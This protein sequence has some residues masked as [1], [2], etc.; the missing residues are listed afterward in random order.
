MFLGTFAWSFVYV[1]LLGPV[2]A[3]TL[4]TWTSPPAVY[5]MMAVLA[6]GPIPALLV[7]ARRRRGPAESAP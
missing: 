4:L 3:T 1:S 6:L 5:L 2:M 7:T